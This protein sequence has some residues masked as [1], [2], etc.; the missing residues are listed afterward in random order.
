MPLLATTVAKEA[1]SLTLK[2]AL[3]SAAQEARSL[4]I[5][6][7]LTVFGCAT[8]S[9]IQR[10]EEP[11]FQ[12]VAQHR[13]DIVRQWAAY[14]VNDPTR[15]MPLPMRLNLTLPFAAD[16]HMSVRECAWMAFRP[17]L[18]AA[19]SEG[20]KLLEPV[21]RSYDANLRRFAVEVS[22]PRSVWGTHIASLKR[23]PAQAL[24]LLENVLQDESK[25]VR[26]SVGNWL[27]DASKT[28]PDWVRAI[29]DRW[30]KNTNKYTEAIIRRGLRT[31]ERR[32]RQLDDE[33]SAGAGIA[34]AGEVPLMTWASRRAVC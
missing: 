13:S 26:L 12:W 29:C 11:A 28:R 8:S 20:L 21:S 3:R 14:A 9:A 18:A 19:L 32:A 4:S 31:L 30:S 16:P 10:F 17:Y 24:A 33:F 34:T 1:P 15:S 6:K 25:Y 7:R 27:N 23:E 2:R 22:R 5:L